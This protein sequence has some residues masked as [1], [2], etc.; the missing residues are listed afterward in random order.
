MKKILLST[1]FLSIQAL[2]AVA[3]SCIE[4]F[5]DASPCLVCPWGV[6][7]NGDFIYWTARQEGLGYVYSQT[8]NPFNNIEIDTKGSV[9]HNDFNF[10]PGFRIGFGFDIRQDDWDVSLTYTWLH[11]GSQTD[12]IRSRDLDHSETAPL[13]LF[14]NTTPSSLALEASTAWALKFNVIDL[15]MG[16]NFFLSETLS[17]KPFFGLKASIQ[18]QDLKQHL[19]AV[20]PIIQEF[21]F[22]SDEDFRYFGLGIR[23]GFDSAWELGKQFSLV[24]SGSLSA[25]YGD[26]E[27]SRKD[28]STD[29]Q[30]PSPQEEVDLY[31]NN[32]FHKINGVFELFLG[33]RWEKHFGEKHYYF[34]TDF[35]FEQQIWMNQNQF[36]FLYEEGSHGDLILQGFTM[37]IRL[38]F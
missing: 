4:V 6:H 20:I 17:V 30:I 26:Y 34:K 35:G 2:Y 5:P 21:S 7:L 32:H 25:L 16:R 9:K 12:Q 37:K 33:V 31:T 14:Q 24:C 22:E 38:D 18:H 13:F 28:R 23:S 1:F 19:S 3:P 8:R 29:L 11:T 36:L 15:Y 27:I 10:D